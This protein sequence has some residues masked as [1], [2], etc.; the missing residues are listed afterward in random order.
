MEQ[1]LSLEIQEGNGQNVAETMK[2]KKK[3]Y[4]FC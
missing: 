2:N 3:K 1:G 4:R